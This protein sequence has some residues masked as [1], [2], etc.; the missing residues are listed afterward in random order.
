LRW[1]E[2]T[3]G[4]HSGRQPEPGTKEHCDRRMQVE[5]TMRLAAMQEDRHAGIDA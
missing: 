3:S 4:L 2:T 5:R 1:I